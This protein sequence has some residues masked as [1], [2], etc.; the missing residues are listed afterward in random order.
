MTVLCTTLI[1]RT[2]S[3]VDDDLRFAAALGVPSIPLKSTFVKLSGT[4]TIYLNACKVCL[5]DVHIFIVQ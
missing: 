1:A 4:F 2:G 3:T 5:Y